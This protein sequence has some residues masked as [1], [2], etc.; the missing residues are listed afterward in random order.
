VKGGNDEN[1]W[2][3]LYDDE[4]NVEKMCDEERYRELNNN[5]EEEEI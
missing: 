5:E 2:V 4:S 1:R 3:G